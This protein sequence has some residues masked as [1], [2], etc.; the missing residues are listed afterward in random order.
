MQG[1]VIHFCYLVAS[2]AQRNFFLFVYVE[3]F[4]V[5]QLA[6]DK[7]GMNK[8]PCKELNL[9]LSLSLSLSLF[10]TF[11][12]RESQEIL[13]VTFDNFGQLILLILLALEK[14]KLTFLPLFHI[15]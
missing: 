6:Y 13:L 8:L 1:F 7:F 14:L 5:Q 15:L 2:I 12:I 9:S 3:Q 4:R 11:S 10:L